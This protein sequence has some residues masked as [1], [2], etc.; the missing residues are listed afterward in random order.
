MSAQVTRS[1]KE[2]SPYVMRGE[3]LQ[4][5]LV[6]V[7]DL[8]NRT[9]S[10]RGV[11][12]DD[13]EDEKPILLHAASKDEQQATAPDITPLDTLSSPL[14]L[15][16]SPRIPRPVYAFDSSLNAKQRKKLKS[17][18][19]YRANRRERRETEQEE[20]GSA[21]KADVCNSAEGMDGARLPY[22]PNVYTLA[23]M[24]GIPG[25]TKVACSNIRET[26]HLKVGDEHRIGVLMGWPD[27]EWPQ[28][29]EGVGIAQRRAHS[30][31]RYTQK[32]CSGRRG[33][34]PAISFG[35]SYGG[36]QTQPMM[37]AHSDHNT[38][39]L[40]EFRS[41]PN[42]QRVVRSQEYAMQAHFSKLH[43]LYTRVLDRLIADE[44]LGLSRNFP[45]TCFAA[46]TLNAGRT[47]TLKH[48]DHLNLFCGM[49]AVFN[50]GDF[51]PRVGGHLVLWDLG[52]IIE[53]PPGCTILFPSALLA[54]S[55]IPI[56]L[57][58]S[59]ASLTQ[60]TAAGLF[61]WVHNGGMSNADYW[62]AASVRQRKAW[63]QH[64]EKLPDMGLDML[65]VD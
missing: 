18:I 47:V 53:F 49:C 14:P 9:V 45:R 27:D 5:P 35:M 51:D 65:P 7:Q 21:L 37:L 23:E 38:H 19:R 8:L 40:E 50:I 60:F 56:G 43:A 36:G 16:R 24:L 13:E 29:M 32:M 54:H 12:E 55:N 33:K 17:R 46:A 25:M 59:R 44:E 26:R 63:L 2:F 64:R 62:E 3:D 10:G 41:D 1:N 42:V 31:L 52:L 61:R 48:V 58:E 30:S 15:R 11:R 39:I 6:S 22:D 20:R 57:G 4:V 28:V 34:F